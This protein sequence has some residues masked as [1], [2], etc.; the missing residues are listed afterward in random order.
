MS[1]VISLKIPVFFLDGKVA[2]L[3]YIITGVACAHTCEYPRN[4]RFSIKRA[5][6]LLGE[7]CTHEVHECVKARP[8]FKEFN[9]HIEIALVIIPT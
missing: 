6:L 3:V 4:L 5:L 1:S 8:N 9:T 7:A 2:N